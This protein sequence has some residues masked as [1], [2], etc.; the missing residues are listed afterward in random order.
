MSSLGHISSQSLLQKIKQG[1]R[2]RPAKPSAKPAPKKTPAPVSDSLPSMAETAQARAA[3]MEEEEDEQR[4]LLAAMPAWIV[5]MLTH[6]V[7]LLALALLTL[8]PPLKPQD[9]PLVV[10]P[11]DEKIEPEEI[12]EDIELD[13]EVTDLEENFEPSEI[14]DLAAIELSEPSRLGDAPDINPVDTSDL[15]PLFADASDWDE[16][17]SELGSGETG[18]GKD[19][20]GP[21][22]SFFGVKTNGNKF[23]FVVDNSNSMNNGRFETAVAELNKAINKLTESQKFYIVFY[24]DTAYPLFYPRTAKTWV[25]A[26]SA[27]KVKLRSWLAGVH[28]CLRTNGREAFKIALSM[29]PDVMYLLGDGAFGD[30]PIPSVMAMK[31]DKI[32]IHTMG[33]NLVKGRGQFEALAKKFKGK[34]HD[35]HV[36]PAMIQYSKQVKRPKNNKQNGAWGIKLGQGIPKKVPPKK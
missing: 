9:A 26:T 21:P 7:I 15:G 20:L 24:S 33:F 17:G 16:L 12:L 32:V 2:P 6:L 1:M 31:N 34:F 19:G 5:S 23:M 28:R 13:P 4:W 36:T 22:I 18:I 35:V 29:E 8:K 14:P 3:A 10:S 30:N 27:N 11:V 25:P